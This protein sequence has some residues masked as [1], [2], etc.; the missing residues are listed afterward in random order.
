MVLNLTDGQWTATARRDVRYSSVCRGTQAPTTDV[1][2]LTPEV[3]AGVVTIDGTP[4]T[5]VS[6]WGCRA[7]VQTWAVTGS[8]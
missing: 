5:S 6:V 3:V 1:L 8:R 7:A 4:S 2:T